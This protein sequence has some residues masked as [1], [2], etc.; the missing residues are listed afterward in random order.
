MIKPVIRD[1][2]ITDSDKLEFSHINNV[3]KLFTLEIGEEN[4]PRK[5]ADEFFLTVCTMDA[6]M[7]RCKLHYSRF[8]FI[9]F[10]HI[11]IVE[12]Y[13]ENRI[14]DLVIERINKVRG[15]TWTEVAEK[16]NGF[17]EYEFNPSYEEELYFD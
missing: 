8:P 4:D 14:K 7:A 3:Y 1:F 17:L 16:L 12:E 10:D 15:K 9:Q 11:M 6:L 2:S 5:G 13:N